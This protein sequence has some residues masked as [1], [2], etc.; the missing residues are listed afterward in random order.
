MNRMKRLAFSLLALATLAIPM[1]ADAAPMGLS[2]LKSM[3]KT[4]AP[5][6]QDKVPGVT[7]KAE[8]GSR[9]EYYTAHTAPGYCLAYTGFGMQLTNIW[10]TTV[11]EEDQVSLVRLV[12][13]DG[14]ASLEE[15]RFT[16]DSNLSGVGASAKTTVPLTE[17]AKT[18]DVTVWAYR[19]GKTITLVTRGVMSGM[20]SPPPMT[21][22]DAM[23]SSV[24]NDHCAFTL[25]RLDTTMQAP[26]A[27][28]VRDTE[29]KKGEATTRTIIDASVSKV[30]RDPEPLLAVRIHTKTI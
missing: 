6:D 23:I 17:V 16:F 3:A 7:V 12:E 1:P 15:S 26:V 10:S 29:P 13:K 8:K 4:G 21:D 28:L 2:S 30:A 20:E 24:S 27:H 19:Q 22:A 14:K 11:K 5:A 9:V 25:A 18:A